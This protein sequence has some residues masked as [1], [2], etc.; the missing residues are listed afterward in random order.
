MDATNTYQKIK[1]KFGDA[2]LQ[3]EICCDERTVE[4]VPSNLKELLAYLKQT[5][6]P[7]F[8]ALIDLTAVDYLEPKL[9]TKVLYFLYNPVTR[10]RLNI[11]TNVPR[12]STLDSVT[13]LWEGANWYEREIYDFFGLHFNGHPNL[14]RILMPDDWEGYPL[15]K[16]YA[17]TEEVVQFKNGVC[18]KVPSK[19]IPHIKG[20]HDSTAE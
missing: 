4:V 16:D 17:L 8:D 15:L 5:P 7:G 18:P 12:L 3:E 14:T 19:I 13:E 10:E 20:N 2:I 9:Q 1:E 11:A 6:E